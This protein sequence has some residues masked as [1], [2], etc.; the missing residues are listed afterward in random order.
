MQKQEKQ[1]PHRKTIYETRHDKSKPKKHHK[2]ARHR[3]EGFNTASEAMGQHEE[4]SK[5]KGMAMEAKL[6]EKRTLILCPQRSIC[7]G[8]DRVPCQ[9]ESVSPNIDDMTQYQV[10]KETE[11][12]VT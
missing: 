4:T 5:H 8:R 3:R 10:E 11:N 9:H 2:T 6:F 1:T 12:I 7:H